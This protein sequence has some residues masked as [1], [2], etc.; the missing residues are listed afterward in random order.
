MGKVKAHDAPEEERSPGYATSERR[1]VLP[2][3]NISFA[4]HRTSSN[5]ET[6]EKEGDIIYRSYGLKSL[7]KR[8][9]SLN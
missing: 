6:H 8:T 2:M 4:C 1:P 7:E 3:L 9:G 5:G